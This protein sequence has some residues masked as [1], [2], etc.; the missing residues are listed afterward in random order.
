MDGRSRVAQK[1]HTIIGNTLLLR[2]YNLII[3]VHVCDF[4]TFFGLPLY[5]YYC[6]ALY[7]YLSLPVIHTHC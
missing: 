4:V 1:I 3:N 2:N 5:S 6:I 7:Y